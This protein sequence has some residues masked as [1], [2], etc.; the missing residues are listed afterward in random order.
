MMTNSTCYKET[1]E[2]PKVGIVVHS[3][4]VNQTALARYIQPSPDDPNKDEILADIGKNIYS[5]SWNQVTVYKGVHAMIGNN[6]AGEV[7]VYQVLPYEKDAWGVASGSRGSYNYAPNAHIQFEM[8]EDDLKHKDYYDK[9]IDSAIDY[10]V[11]L[12]KLFGWDETVICSHK[13]CAARGYGSFHGDPE[14]WMT[15][16]GQDMDW[17]RAEVKE[18]LEGQTVDFNVGDK[19]KFKEGVTT[20]ANGVEMASWVPKHE[21]YYVKAVFSNGRVQVSWENGGAATG[22]ARATDLILIQEAP[23]PDPDDIQDGEDGKIIFTNTQET[24][25]ENAKIEELQKEIPLILDDIDASIK[26]MEYVKAQVIALRTKID[27]INGV[28]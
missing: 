26:Q 22:T 5:N 12:C 16:Y 24:L 2:S 11:Y 14:N 1:S 21:P 15:L 23:E 25:I 6:A 7:E 19:V 18:R 20:W 28:G 13:E 8:L 4:G 9:V 3:T 27:E 17:F 10:C